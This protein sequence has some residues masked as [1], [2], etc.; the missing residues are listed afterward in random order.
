MRSVRLYND[1]WFT[2]LCVCIATAVRP[3]RRVAP[4]LSPERLY[5]DAASKYR[6]DVIYG[7]KHRFGEFAFKTIVVATE[8]KSL[9]ADFLKWTRVFCDIS[10]K[11]NP[12]RTLV[13][14][15][16]KFDTRKLFGYSSG[17][18]CFI[19][20]FF[21]II[22]FFFCSRYYSPFWPLNQHLSYVFEYNLGRVPSCA[23]VV[24]YMGHF[25]GILMRRPVKLERVNEPLGKRLDGAGWGGLIGS[26]GG[27]DVGRIAHNSAF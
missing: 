11:K 25:P 22:F 8:P 24:L 19:T 27:V 10:K 7:V 14:H 13:T 6:I 12:R 21:I 9:S 26:W 2:R 20:G 1:I 15:T 16:F 3:G 17:I 23:V 5:K 18:P 4:S